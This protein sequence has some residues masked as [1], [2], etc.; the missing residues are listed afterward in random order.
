MKVFIY[1]LIAACFF[2]TGITLISI[3]NET[4]DRSVSDA[5]SQAHFLAAA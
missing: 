5:H 3:W 2:I 1:A 4:V